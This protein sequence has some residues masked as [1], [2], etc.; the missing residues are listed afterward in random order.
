MYDPI[1]VTYGRASEH[2][3]KMV[4]RDLKERCE[5]DGTKV[6]LV[7][8]SRHC[9][10]N[11]NMEV[12]F[13]NSV[14]ETDCFVIQSGER[15]CLPDP[16]TA[17]MMI[18]RDFIELCHLSRAARDSARRVSAVTPYYYYARSDKKDKPRIPIGAKLMGDLLEAAGASRILTMDMHC[19]QTQGNANIPVDQ[20][21]SMPKFLKYFLECPDVDLSELTIVAPDLGSAKRC[22]KFAKRL[23]AA[24]L[25]RHDE[26]VFIPITII[27]K[28][29]YDDS[30]Q[31]ETQEVIGKE[32]LPGR[33]VIIL[34]DEIL[35]GGT[36]IEVLD[37]LAEFKTKKL[38]AAMTHG[39]LSGE[40]VGRVIDSSLERLIITDTVE[41]LDPP[42]KIEVVSV[43]DDFAE[44]IKRI[45]AGRSVSEM[46]T[47]G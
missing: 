28:E 26:K 6:S 43:V 36:L 29:R 39:V 20:I 10:S 33:C 4:Y 21:F 11:G 3:A 30:E 23:R 18:S 27:N 22:R 44:L 31:P 37:I 13:S 2:F 41:Y 19:M 15:S 38:F 9:F 35:G 5:R 40:A 16:E 32:H 12:N 14:R 7:E 25:K 46:D 17:T 45:H 42:E 24:I 1:S 47:F 8:S 34:D